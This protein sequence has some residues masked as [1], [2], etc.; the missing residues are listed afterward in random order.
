MPSLRDARPAPAESSCGWEPTTCESGPT[1]VSIDV[2]TPKGPI[3]F[4]YGWL[5]YGIGFG[6][7]TDVRLTVGPEFGRLPALLLTSWGNPI[8]QYG[9]GGADT[10]GDHPADITIVQC[11]DV[12]EYTKGTLHVV[13]NEAHGSWDAGFS[14][15]LDASLSIASDGIALD[16]AFV[17]TNLC[18]IFSSH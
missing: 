9:G 6:I 7:S 10:P 8:D 12:Y 4:N 14:V 2:R 3:H 17:I 15:K 5:S 16:G 11:G 13:S 1:P 18:G